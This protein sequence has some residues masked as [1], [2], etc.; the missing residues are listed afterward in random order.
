LTRSRIGDELKKLKLDRSF[1][2]LLVAALIGICQHAIR[3]SASYRTLELGGDASTIGAIAASYAA[4]ALFFAIPLGRALDRSNSKPY[5]IGGSAILVLGAGLSA[6]APTLFALGAAQALAGL[7]R[8][9]SGV[10]IQTMVANRRNSDRDQGFARLAVASSTGQLIGPVVAGF[11]LDSPIDILPALSRSGLAL[12][13]ASIFGLAGIALALR[14]VEADAPRQPSAAPTDETRVPLTSILSRKGVPQSLLVG[15]A[16]MSV[17]DLTTV[18]LPLLGESR[19]IPASAIGLLLSVRAGAGFLSR[20]ALGHMVRRWGRR[21]ILLVSMLLAALSLLGI[22]FST[23]T[24]QLAILLFIV[25]YGLGIGNP[26]TLAW[27]AV[28]APRRE[29]ATAIALRVTGNRLAQIVLPLSFGA[30]GAL[31]GPGS[32]FVGMATMLLVGAG[33]LRASPADPT[34]DRKD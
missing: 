29:R 22:A 18:Y 5:L 30:L 1:Q 31:V 34:V 21:L 10:S 33:V 7:G 26:L 14:V 28:E 16:A 13:A 32:V 24:F 11:A 17:I 15:L 23:A 25:G 9:V 4:I 27:L 12:L 6:I 19:G 2:F 20:L 3:P 8:M